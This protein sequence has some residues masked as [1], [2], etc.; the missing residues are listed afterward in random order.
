MRLKELQIE[1]FKSFE[2]SV[3]FHFPTQITG[4]VGPN[5]SGKSNV[6]EAFRFV[7]GEQSMKT[8]R[9]RRGGDL[10]FNGGGGRNRLSRAKVTLIFDNKD[11]KLESHFNTVQLQRIVLQD[12]TNEYYI[13]DTQVRHKDIVELLAKANI[14]TSG[15][16]II[17]Q[18][19]AD[20]ILNASPEDRREMVEDGLGLKLL[21]YQRLESIKRL[22]KAKEHVRQTESLQRELAPNL[23]YLR[24]QVDQY[25]QARDLREKLKS[26]YTNYL[27]EESFSLKKEKQGKEKQL[28][29][30]DSVIKVLD[31]KIAA[32]KQK[33]EDTGL[34]EKFREKAQSLREN[35]Q[36]IRENKDAL[37]REI[38]RIDGEAESLK[39]IEQ[40]S[41]YKEIVPIAPI[42]DKLNEYSEVFDKVD[43]LD[44][45]KHVFQ[46]LIGA[47][48][49]LFRVGGQEPTADVES[50][51][52]AIKSRKVQ[53]QS[54]L[55][56]LKDRES[57]YEKEQQV[58]EK[59]QSEVLMSS[60]S[61]EQNLLSLVTE[62]NQ[63]EKE[64]SE[65]SH[66][67]YR[68]AEDEEEFQRELTEGLVLI[69]G[70]VQGYMSI[71][72]TSSLN[73]EERKEKRRELEKMKIK[74][75]S[76]SVAEDS[77]VLD[78]YQELEKRFSFLE[79]EKQ[80]VLESI[81]SLSQAILELQKEIDTRFKKGITLINQEFA[82][83]F[84]L[85]FG[86]GKSKIEEIKL[87]P[88]KGKDEDD[89]EERKGLDINLSLPHKKINSLD[90]L[91]GGERALVSIALLFSI[92]QV[93]PPPFLIL[94]ETDAAL[95]EANSRRYGDMIEALAKKSQLLL[96]THNRET[97]YRAGALYGVTMGNTG[98]S[99][100]LSV[101]FEE[102]VSVAK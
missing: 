39:T 99:T 11:K 81:R 74:L 64:R 102:A 79:K 41:S 42:Q 58:L 23:R 96:I 40:V 35:L 20:S 59:E 67:L 84:K 45:A 60:Q 46:E 75:E 78:E 53:K 63:V 89:E 28:K 26:V 54:E 24:K 15:H 47:I 57:V 31:G 13:N 93:T 9:G 3:T 87:P 44:K 95:D 1:G 25:N 82:T 101:Q 97:M 66:A 34:A 38:G 6:T 48:E 100:V 92:S 33:H 85:L 88:K 29:E 27:A 76:M 80:D 49:K 18:G 91:S 32:E 2:K 71:E 14:G 37:I 50:R 36:R 65:I 21:Q 51:L 90:Q 72:V 19:E 61:Q 5:G 8:L 17:S 73:R 56:S 52:N 12:G 43:S 98:T 10:I 69:G 94:D 4:I 22:E 30:I 68:V 86:G 16:N 62:K 55:D 7:L 77:T 70:A 83:F